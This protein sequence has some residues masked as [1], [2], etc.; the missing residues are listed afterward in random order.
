M[1]QLLVLFLLCLGLFTLPTTVLA[2][3]AVGVRFGSPLSLSF[4]TFLVEESHAVE[5]F[6]GIRFWSFGFNQLSVGGLYQKHFDI[7]IDDLEGLQWYVGGGAS[8]NR[9]IVRDCSA[10]G[11][12]G[13]IGIIGNAGLNYIFEDLPLNLSVDWT[14][15]LL[16]GNGFQSSAFG[17]GGYYALSVRYVLGRN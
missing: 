16:V 15:T 11:G 8:Y 17:W 4:K 10:C 1:K 14:P 5:A 6:A 9:F 13:A 7:G 3:S 2:Q 12:N